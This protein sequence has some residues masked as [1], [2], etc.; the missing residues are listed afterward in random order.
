MTKPW[1]AI[2]CAW[3]VMAL[4]A[5]L[6]PLAVLADA[7]TAAC[8]AFGASLVVLAD[9]STAAC[10]AS[11][12]LLVVLADAGTAACCAFGALL[13]VLA[14]ASTAACCA[15]GASLVVLTDAGIA[16]CCAIGASLVVRTLL[17]NA[18][19][20]WMRCRGFRRCCRSCWGC[21]LIH[22]VVAASTCRELWRVA[23]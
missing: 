6:V 19:L 11:G 13:V 2:N 22:S 9:A 20:Y 12:A 23:F 15:F 7:G 5:R 18:P 10:Y 4:S 1:A 17:P 16:A 21:L 14:D 8:C 3:E